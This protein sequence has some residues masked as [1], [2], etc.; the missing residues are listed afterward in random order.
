VAEND[1]GRVVWLLDVD[2]VINV[3]RPGWGG[4]ARSGYAFAGG[5]GFR[6]RWAPAL[7][8]RIRALHD[9][10][11]VDIRWCSTWCSDASQIEDLLGLPPLIRSWT[12]ERI[13]SAASMAKL[14]TARAV[15]AQ[16]N[17]LVWTDD[18]ETPTSGPV[19]EELARPGA[20]HRPVAGARPATRAPRTD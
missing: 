6:I 14:A 18:A 16:G 3:S 19:F 10:G 2:G 8:A 13:G 7:V 4:P 5:Q 11:R 1:I 20:A 15:L 17:R 12:E 9:A